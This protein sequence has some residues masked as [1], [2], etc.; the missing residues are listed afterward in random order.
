MLPAIALLLVLDSVLA[1]DAV[2]T[3]PPPPPG[4]TMPFTGAGDP[5]AGS[6]FAGSLIETFTDSSWSTYVMGA[7]V[8]RSFARC[9]HSRVLQQSYQHCFIRGR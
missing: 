4:V 5:A 9:L 1:Q 2:P 8:V 3:C 6:P 7:L